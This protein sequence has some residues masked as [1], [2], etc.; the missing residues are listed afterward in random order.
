[1]TENFCRFVTFFISLIPF[2]NQCARETER[3]FFCSENISI[4]YSILDR[5]YITEIRISMQTRAF[6]IFF[7]RAKASSGQGLIRP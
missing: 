5:A 1:M 3:I 2:L 7:C 4:K 6:N